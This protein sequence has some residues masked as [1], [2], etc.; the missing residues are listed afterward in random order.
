MSMR[1]RT[2]GVFLNYEL[3]QFVRS[4][5]VRA[6][7]RFLTSVHEVDVLLAAENGTSKVCRLSVH[8]E[9]GAR[10]IGAGAHR[11]VEGAV[12]LAAEKLS[13]SVARIYKR[14]RKRRR[15]S[16]ASA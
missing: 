3:E 8:L 1:I 5:V 16:G 6:L 13:R 7:N 2:H 14:Q 10:S 15:D 9:H 12:C 4:K 11:D